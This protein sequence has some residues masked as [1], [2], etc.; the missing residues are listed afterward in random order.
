MRTT[1][2]Q[3]GNSCGVQFPRDVVEKAHLGKELEMEV[4]EGAVV[5]RAAQIV[6]PD[7]SQAA[8]ACHDAGDDFLDDWDA[9]AGDQWSCDQ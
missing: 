5:I 1:L 7:W 6:R 8:A 3:I 2:I 4:V 9:V